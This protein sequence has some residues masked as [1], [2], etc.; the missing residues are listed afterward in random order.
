[1]K[2][3]ARMPTMEVVRGGWIPSVLCMWE[4]KKGEES[5]MIPQALGAWI[6][7]FSKPENL[8][9]KLWH[10]EDSKDPF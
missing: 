10:R 1:M 4:V 3:M 6:V 8:V 5:R 9:G 2:G 7:P